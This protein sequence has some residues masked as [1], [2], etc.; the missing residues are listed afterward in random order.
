MTPRPGPESNG[1]VI[2]ETLTQLVSGPLRED[3]LFF[4]LDSKAEREWRTTSASFAQRPS[5]ST[6]SSTHDGFLAGSFPR[7]ITSGSEVTPVVVFLEDPLALLDALGA[8]HAWDPTRLV[9]VCLSAEANMTRILGHPTVQRSE[10]IFA[11]QTARRHGA[12]VF[13][14]STSLPMNRDSRGRSLLKSPLGFW[15]PQV[16][17]TRRDIF[18]PRFNN[19]GGQELALATWCDDTPYLYLRE[20]ECTGA[21]VEVFRMIASKLNF[22]FDIQMEPADQSWGTLENGTWVGMMADLERNGKHVAINYFLLNSDRARDFDFTYPYHSEGFAFLIHLPP[23]LP[24]WNRVLYPFSAGMWGA[25][26]ASTCLVATSLALLLG[27]VDGA[28]DVSSTIIKVSNIA[29]MF[30]H[31]AL[32]KYL[33]HEYRR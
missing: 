8:G 18:P 17:N 22:S 15:D 21:N 31:S 6:L 20:G 23:P 32:T 9:L 4:L 24:N 30:V 11:L 3:D 29:C 26:I 25:V 2:Q 16:F 19:F 10:F 28:P 7:W 1:D 13:E 5:A 33:S 27:C 12:T 14:A